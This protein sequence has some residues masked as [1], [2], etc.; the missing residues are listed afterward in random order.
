[1][2]AEMG[3]RAARKQLTSRELFL[4]AFELF[5]SQG[6]DNTT[7]EQIAERVG[8][9]KRTFFRYFANKE[10][11]VLGNLE[12]TA[13]LLGMAMGERPPGEPMWLSLRRSFDFFVEAT[14]QDPQRVSDN[15]RV[16]RTSPALKATQLGKLQLWQAALMPELTRRVT[17]E[18]EFPE[19]R[20]S[21]IAGAALACLDAALN[22]WY[23]NP[24]ERSLGPILDEAMQSVAPLH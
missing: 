16:V 7:V 12:H 18:Q 2:T 1:M 10:D 6:Y 13:T 3:V 9:S 15:I 14:T 19:M 22:A 4:A 20:A 24:V 11:L 23:L 8:I 21:A 5:G 17:T